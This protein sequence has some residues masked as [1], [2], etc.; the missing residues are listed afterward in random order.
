[1]VLLREVLGEIKDKASYSASC[2]GGHGKKTLFFSPSKE[3]LICSKEKTA[4]RSFRVIAVT[5]L[6]SSLHG[7]DHWMTEEG[8]ESQ[9]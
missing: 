8:R 2:F 4:I 9:R 1:M 3:L 7:W 5:P 6:D